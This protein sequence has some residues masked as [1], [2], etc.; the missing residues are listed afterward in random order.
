MAKLPRAQLVDP[1]V[2]G[3]IEFGGG[4]NVTGVVTATGFEGNTTG[5]ATN[6][7]GSPN[8]VGAIVTATTYKGSGSGI[9]GLAGTSYIGQTT[10]FTSAATYTIDLS[11]GNVVHIEDGGFNGTATVGFS[12][13]STG[14]GE[15]RIVRK[16]ICAR[17]NCEIYL[18]WPSNITWEGDGQ[19][20]DS[21]FNP[22][23]NNVQE[24]T[25]LTT[26]SGAS[27]YGSE[28]VRSDPST[29][30]VW[31]WGWEHRKGWFGMNAQWGGGDGSCAE[32]SK[33]SSPVS[34]GASWMSGCNPYSDFKDIQWGHYYALGLKKDGTLWSW[35][36]NTQGVLGTNEDH[37]ISRSSPVQIGIDSDWQSLGNTNAGH[38]ATAGAIKQN[39]T[40][41]TW[42]NGGSGQLGNN[43]ES[44]YSVPIQI[45][46]CIG[47]R[48]K[49][50]SFGQDG[51]L[52]IDNCG[53]LWGFGRN[54]QAQRSAGQLGTSINNKSQPAK[55]CAALCWKAIAM[56]QSGS[57]G[58]THDGKLYSW[59]CGHYGQTGNSSWANGQAGFPCSP[60]QV[61]TDT[62]WKCVWGGE[63]NG[64]GL[65]GSN[66]LW[67]WGSHSSGVIGC[68]VSE[69]QSC[70]S[71]GVSSPVRTMGGD[72]IQCLH[73]AGDSAAA[74][75]CC[76]RLWTWGSN[77]DGK[78]GINCCCAN[79]RVSSP[80]QIMNDRKFGGVSGSFC[81]HAAISVTC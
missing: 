79:K 80:V 64:A 76:G 77:Q 65:K 78:R 60:R 58:V 68:N 26:N 39:G 32:C 67:M 56:M 70:T 71:G 8:V 29:T 51:A 10:S 74:V 63:Y 17:C 7:T 21:I 69:N 43:R 15:V 9:T 6:L 25:L 62:D 24:I 22:R 47:Y 72:Y 18:N 19:K 44:S 33:Y 1:S 59:G 49:C 3:H 53:T 48:W 34:I 5:T 12:N 30:N 35:G 37:S 40:M 54:Y 2:A 66:E 16:P 73:L 27:W 42:G 36:Q 61:G 46:H 50:L 28:T 13:T 23:C 75:D 57:L 11:K 31:A 81:H 41:W 38:A 52:A 14:S 45:C 20:P 4:I 55:V